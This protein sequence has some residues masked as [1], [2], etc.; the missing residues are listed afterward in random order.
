MADILREKSYAFA[1]RILGLSEYLHKD[2]NEYVISR[3]VPRFSGK[4][5][6]VDRRR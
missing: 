1:L 2:K 3:K 5:R 4:Y 6:T